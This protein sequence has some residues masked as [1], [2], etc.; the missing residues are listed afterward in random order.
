MENLRGIVR[1]MNTDIIGT[2]SVYNGLRKIKGIS[3]MFCNAICNTLELEKLRKIGTLSE[4]EVKKIESLIKNPEMP[5][6]MLNRRKDYDT[7][8]NLHLTGADLIFSKEFDVKRL[9]KVKSYRGIRHAIGQPLRGQ[10]TRSHFRS[11]RSVGVQRKS[12]AQ[13]PA[14]NKDKK[15]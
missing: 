14:A 1:I 15:K 4:E 8:N 11:G 7:G 10:R 5:N 12:V 13:K 6:W 3:F 9:K 2:K